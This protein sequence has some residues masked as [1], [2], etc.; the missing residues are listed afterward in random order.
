MTSKDQWEIRMN[1]LDDNEEELV[2]LRTALDALLSVPPSV[3]GQ[4]DLKNRLKRASIS[5]EV[6]DAVLASNN[7]GARNALS[8]LAHMLAKQIEFN[9]QVKQMLT[10]LDYRKSED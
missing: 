5:P 2:E 4:E 7:P 8:I 6:V 1:A 3:G 10:D 9:R